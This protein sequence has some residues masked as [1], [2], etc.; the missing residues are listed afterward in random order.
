MNGLSRL[1]RLYVDPTLVPTAQ[2]G[3]PCLLTPEQARYLGTVLRKKVGEQVRVF[4]AGMG[5]WLASIAEI[6]KDRGG[7]VLERPLRAPQPCPPLPLAFA[8][9]KRDATDLVLR[10]GTELGVS[11]FLPLV[12][13]RT[14]TH[15]IN[16]ERL[17]AI[18]VEAAE[19]CERLDIPTIAQVQTLP[20]LLGNWPHQTSLFAA[21]ERLDKRE[22]TLHLPTRQV[23]EG[24]GLLIGP[25]GGLSDNE[26][27]TLLKRPFVVPVSL[28]SLVLR[29]DTAVVAGLAL[30]GNG[31]RSAPVSSQ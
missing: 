2:K 3:A 18:A 4:H 19:Q 13:E 22:N 24:D 29:A 15:R 1:P 8:L 20:A 23:Q 25:E 26:C 27:Q 31:L 17:H 28:G 14:N 12:T 16:P 11:E 21:I 9:L 10:M 30:L 5:E 7:L 6:R